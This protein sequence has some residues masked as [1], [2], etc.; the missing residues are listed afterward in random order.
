MYCR[1]V[2]D[3]CNKWEI[4]VLYDKTEIRFWQLPTDQSKGTVIIYLTCINPQLTASGS[5][6]ILLVGISFVKMISGIHFIVLVKTPNDWKDTF[7]TIHYDMC[8]CCYTQRKR[9]SAHGGLL[10]CVTDFF[11]VSKIVMNN[12][13]TV[14]GGCFCPYQWSGETK[15]YGTREYIDTAHDNN[16]TITHTFIPSWIQSYSPLPTIKDTF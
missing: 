10:K 6:E 12:N 7:L 8:N 5:K 2:H 11:H 13:S 14:W 4:L 1:K 16:V 9:C 15:G 3:M